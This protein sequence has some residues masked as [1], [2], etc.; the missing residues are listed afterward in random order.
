MVTKA[1]TQ[2]IRQKRKNP[3]QKTVL[4]SVSGILA[5]LS[6]AADQLRLLLCNVA[7]MIS[8]EHNCCDESDEDVSTNVLHDVLDE[9]PLSEIGEEFVKHVCAP[10]SIFDDPSWDRLSQTKC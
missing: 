3:T 10:F 2:P 4:A 1:K 8:H 9:C 6:L 5:G 7:D